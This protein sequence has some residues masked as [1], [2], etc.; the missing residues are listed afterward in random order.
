L[1]TIFTRFTA[2]S[3]SSSPPYTF[4]PLIF[5]NLLPLIYVAHNL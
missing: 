2:Y 4:L 3:S 5:I 1:P